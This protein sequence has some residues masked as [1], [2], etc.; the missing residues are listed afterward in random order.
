MTHMPS[1]FYDS[2]AVT[3]L[4]LTCR[5]ISMTHMQSHFWLTC[6]HISMT[7]MP[8]HFYDS[9]AVTFLWLTC[10][11]I[12]DSHAVTFLWLTCRHISD[13]HAVTFL[14]LTCP[15]ISMTHVPS[16]FRRQY[17]CE[18][19]QPSDKQ[20]NEFTH[21]FYVRIINQHDALFFHFIVLPRFYAFVHVSDPFVAH[22]R[23]AVCVMW[24][25]VLVL[26]LN[27]LSA[28]LARP[29]P[30]ESRQY[31]IDCS[32]IDNLSEGTRNAPWRWQCN[33]ETCRSYHT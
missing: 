13:S 19:W 16:H 10:P 25:M 12:S 6:R 22:H 2:H 20:N 7:H 9:H 15:H 28:G 31:S 18:V 4:W 29:R 17:S 30:A 8:S 1:H 27:R 5:H 32:S 26:L 33:A 24:R 21:P 11:H 23:E 14:W 3:F